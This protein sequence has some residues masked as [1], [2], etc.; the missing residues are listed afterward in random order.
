MKESQ[1]TGEE[2]VNIR[3]N[4]KAIR[5][6]KG[7]SQRVLSGI[8]DIPAG[9]LSNHER[10]GMVTLENLRKYSRF[11][12]LDSY[13]EFLRPIPEFKKKYCVV[14]VPYK[15]DN[16]DDL[17]EAVKGLDQFTKNWCM[18]VAE[19]ESTGELAF[20]CNVCEFNTDKGECLVKR[21]AKTAMGGSGYPMNKFGSMSH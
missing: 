14:H 2:R 15:G 20:R 9:T 10:T 6:I 21:F 5:N 18:D 11:Y 3:A 8:V 1:W 12:K 13:K 7:Y 19:T 16:Q 17:Y 4:L